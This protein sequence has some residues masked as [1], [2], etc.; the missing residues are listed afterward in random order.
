MTTHLACETAAGLERA[1]HSRDNRVGIVLHP[2]QRRIGKD[3]VELA[4]EIEPRAVGHARDK[5]A[6]LRCRDHV[7]R[8]IDAHH[9]GTGGDNFFRQHTVPASEVENMLAGLRLEQIEHGLSEC[10]NEMSV[11]C[12]AFGLP[13]LRGR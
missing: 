11:L 8:G 4:R 9:R 10:G 6:L 12:V 7:R 2:M 1:R 3:R 5:A 13:A